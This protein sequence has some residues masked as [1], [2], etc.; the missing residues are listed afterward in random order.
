MSLLNWLIRPTG[1]SSTDVFN[2]M[3]ITAA[4]LVAR[5]N[6]ATSA[7]LA[8]ARTSGRVSYRFCGARSGM[9]DL[10]DRGENCNVRTYVGA[11][12]LSKLVSMSRVDPGATVT[13]MRMQSTLKASD[14]TQ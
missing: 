7:D 6:P 5:S 12:V 14:M 9:A 4:A 1:V 8:R 3:V 10:G 13:R 2:A 11:T